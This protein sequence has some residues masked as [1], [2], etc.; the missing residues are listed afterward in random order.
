MHELLYNYYFWSSSEIVDLK[1]ENQRLYKRIDELRQ[2]QVSLETQVCTRSYVYVRKHKLV[3][4]VFLTDNL[5]LLLSHKQ[6]EKLQ[7]ELA[8]E[9]LRYRDECDARKLLV[10]DIND[11]KYQQ[12]DMLMSKQ[13]MED[14]EEEEKDD[15]VTLKIALRFEENWFCIAIFDTVDAVT[16]G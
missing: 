13:S 11:L 2:E 3:F 8:A 14:L 1:K 4:F 5:F 9:Y 10:T 6:V 16:L 15:P 12:E 7:E